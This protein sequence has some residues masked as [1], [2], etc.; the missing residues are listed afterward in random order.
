MLR[1]IGLI[2]FI[3]KINYWI[4]KDP[5]VFHAY[6]ITLPEKLS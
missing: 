6:L 3:M 1:F 4:R 5:V 2:V